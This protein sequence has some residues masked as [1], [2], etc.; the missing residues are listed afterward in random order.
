MPPFLTPDEIYGLTHLVRPSAQ[1]RFL[2]EMDVPSRRRPDGTLLVLRRDLE[3]DSAA[4]ERP[5]P[6]LAA[7][8]AP[9]TQGERLE[10][11]RMVADRRAGRSGQAVHRAAGEARYA[12]MN[13]GAVHFAC[14][15]NALRQRWE[16]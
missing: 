9:Q 6:N 15:R 1:A 5:R 4:R 13:S 12:V 10:A 7:V 8:R 3:R 11:S 16:M 2:A 14:S